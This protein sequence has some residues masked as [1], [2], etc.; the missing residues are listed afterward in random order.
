[1]D[2]DAI[3]LQQRPGWASRVRSIQGVVQHGRKLGRQL[4]FPTA[5]VALAPGREPTYGVYAALTRLADG[6]IFPGVASVGVRPT[7]G[8]VEPLLEVWMFGFDEDIYGATIRTELV[9]FLRGEEKFDNLDI[10]TRQVM[11]DAQ[12]AKRVLGMTDHRAD[13]GVTPCVAVQDR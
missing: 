11:A 8:G 12:E 5:N 3:S 10:L 4:G 7:V 1:M 2:R 9:K 6:R 13:Q